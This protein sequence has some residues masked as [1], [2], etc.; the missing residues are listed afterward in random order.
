M[1][2]HGAQ[3]YLYVRWVEQPS[4]RCGVDLSLSSLPTTAA[5]L[6]RV[7]H[8]LYVQPSVSLISNFF[9]RFFEHPRKNASLLSSAV[10]WC[11]LYI[12]HEFDSYYCYLYK[13]KKELI[14]LFPYLF[15]RRWR[16]NYNKTFL[17][18]YDGFFFQC[19]GIFHFW[20]LPS[21]LCHSQFKGFFSIYVNGVK[22]HVQH[23]WK[24]NLYLKGLNVI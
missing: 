10:I 4:S 17:L 16:K 24:K 12:R 9:K 6:T 13:K 2:H 21:L 15:V 1:S 5:T 23:S 11:F 19:C 18:F 7:K 14:K 8:L 20:I 22:M 3:Y